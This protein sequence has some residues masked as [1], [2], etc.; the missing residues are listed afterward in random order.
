[1]TTTPLT[2]GP[3][4]HIAT[5][6]ASLHDTVAAL[7]PVGSD[8]TAVIH[9]GGAWINHARVRVATAMVLPGMQIAVHTPPAHALPCVLPADAVLWTDKW[10][11]AINKPAG[12][13][14]DAT[15]WDAENH[16]RTALTDHWYARTGELLQLHPAHRLDRDTTGVLLFTRHSHANAPLQKVFVEQRA[17]KTYVCLVTGWPTWDETTLVSGHGRS[18]RG[19]FRVYPEADIGTAL[20]GGNTVKRMETRFRVITRRADGSSLL[21]AWPQTGR[22]H[23]IRLHAHALG[24]PI[25]GDTTYSTGV[26]GVDTQHLHAWQLAL[27][28]PI[29]AEPL[30]LTAPPPAWCAA[31][32]AG[33]DPSGTIQP[34]FD[35]RSSDGSPM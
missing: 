3:Y 27:P 4:A 16:L 35:A 12:T 9:R 6:T 11:I 5:V 10:L 31:D 33:I 22:T 17:H 34:A 30:A 32:L 13:Y 7:L 14:V 23:Q 2:Q 26:L 15:P 8:A 24:L 29:H 21:L 28:H 18:D 1:M 20:P 19:R 25:V